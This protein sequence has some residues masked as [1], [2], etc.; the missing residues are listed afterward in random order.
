MSLHERIETEDLSLVG[1]SK[2][3]GE[4]SVSSYTSVIRPGVYKEKEVRFAWSSEEKLVR[5]EVLRKRYKEGVGGDTLG[6]RET[7]I[8]MV[9]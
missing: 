7:R 1:I 9:T 5:E 6:S 4:F 8:R 2:E 3:E